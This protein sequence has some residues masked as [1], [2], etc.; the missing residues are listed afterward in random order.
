MPSN[1]NF[2][3]TFF[4]VFLVISIIF[5]LNK[6]GAIYY[7]TTS[8]I[9]LIFVIISFSKPKILQPLNLIWYKFGILLSIIITPIIMLILFIIMFIPIG[10]YKRVFTKNYLDIKLDRN[11]G[12][13]W[14]KAESNINFDKQF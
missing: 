13:Y 11:S 3:V 6:F 8:L 4:F 1:K 9:G 14:K 7:A 2:G 10:I 5:Y 12:S